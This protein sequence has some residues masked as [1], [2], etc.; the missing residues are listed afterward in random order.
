MDTQELYEKLREFNEDELFYRN[1]YDAKQNQWKLEEFLNGLDYKK[2][3]DRRLIITEVNTGYMPSDMT[4]ETYFEPEDKNSIV[5]SKHNRFTPAFRH[6][7]IFFEMIYVLSGSCVQ[8]IGQEEIHLKEGEFCLIAPN[9][10]HSISVY[11][12]SI[13]INIL[14]RRS[15]FED[16]FYDILRDTNKISVFFNQSLF[17]NLQNTHLIFDTRRDGML[18]EHVLTM[19]LEYI[20]NAKYYEKILNSQLMILFGKLLQIYEDCIKYPPQTRKT[21]ETCMHIIA[22][23]E[24][25]YQTITLNEISEHFHFSPA[26]CSRLIKEY[27][28]KSFTAI[29]QSIKFKKAVSLLESTNISIA[30]V[31]H[32]VGFE[33]VEH[34]NRLFKK[35]Y[36]VTPGQYRKNTLS[37]NPHLF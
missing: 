2:I 12:S 36:Q 22:Y 24:D 3:L 27:T 15:T 14:I 8:L 32:L 7:H 1:Y 17:A 25:H 19:F 16:I 11:D 37:V 6:R 9:V 26:Y 28:G 5:I 31:S 18:K 23:I 34:F 4:D 33:N 13:I 29:V 30:E 10:T 21:N 35:L 20:N